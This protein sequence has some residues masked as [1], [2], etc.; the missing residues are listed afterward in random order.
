M[1]DANYFVDQSK[2]IMEARAQERDV[3]KVRSMAKIVAVFNALTDLN[4]N[5]ADG[6]KFMIALKLVRVEVRFHED[7]IF[8]MIAYAALLGEELS[9]QEESNG[10]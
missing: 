1:N 6:W 2:V 3:A 4:L 9:K 5:V 10:N 8:D 7:G